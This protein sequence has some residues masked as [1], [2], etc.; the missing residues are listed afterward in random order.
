MAGQLKTI[1]KLFDLIPNFQSPGIDEPVV[2]VGDVDQLID[3]VI[4]D[5]RAIEDEKRP[6]ESL[7]VA[8][9]GGD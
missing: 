8:L 1:P 4:E 6:L 5:L 9:Q 3:W 2:R 7:A